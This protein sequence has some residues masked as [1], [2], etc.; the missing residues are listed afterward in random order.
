MYWSS[1]WA[2]RGEMR[3]TCRVEKKHVAPQEIRPASGRSRGEGE[4][5]G[6]DEGLMVVVEIYSCLVLPSLLCSVLLCS[7]CF[8]VRSHI[9]FLLVGTGDWCRV[10][11]ESR[12]AD[13]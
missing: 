7:W 8:L 13:R 11:A 6:A 2:N 3:E 10:L 5:D 1:K 9:Y 12:A 4:G